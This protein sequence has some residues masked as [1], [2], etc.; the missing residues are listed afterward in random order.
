MATP[1]VAGCVA[2][3]REALQEHGKQQP[4]TAL[5]KALLI[6]G[7][8]NYSSSEAPS[9]DNQQN[10]GRVDIGNSIAIIKQSAFVEG[11]SKLEATVYDVP[12]L[13]LTPVTDSRCKSPE[14]PI[15]SGPNRL[16]VTLAY[17]DAPG[18]LLQKDVNLLVRAGEVKRH[19][20]M[21]SDMGFDHISKFS[22]PV[23][24]TS[25]D[26]IVDNVETIIWNDVL[27]TTVTIVMQAYAFTKLD[28]EQAFAVA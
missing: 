16:L 7:A 26:H 20:N 10:F 23:H 5:V 2:L 8:V 9:F 28:S 14:I 1:L 17:P 19:G 13:H 22:C 24:G 27:G 11:G 3:I 15:P 25:T 12:A 18:A 4:S 6:N 21:G